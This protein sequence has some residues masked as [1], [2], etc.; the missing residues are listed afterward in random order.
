MKDNNNI[1]KDSIIKDSVE[2]KFY[3]LKDFDISVE[4][5]DLGSEKAFAL[6]VRVH[7]QNARQGT[8]A[9]KTRKDLISRS[10]K[11]PWRQKG[12]GRARAGTARSPLWRGGAVSHPP[13]M[14]VRRLYINKNVNNSAFKYLINLKF[15]E[16][17]ICSLDWIPNKSC[18]AAF[19][20]LKENKI[21]DKKLIVFYEINDFDTFFSF[22]NLSNVKLISYDAVGAYS[23]GTKAILVFLEKD[24]NLFKEMVEKWII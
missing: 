22:S 8:L 9:C 18:S 10:N 3:Q 13:M 20:I 5:D 7:R 4:A 12:T 2:V 16:K 21:S 15:D 1:A 6:S 11:K 19:K 14:R 17:S 24:K 23:I